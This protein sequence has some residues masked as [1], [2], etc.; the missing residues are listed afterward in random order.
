MVRASLQGMAFIRQSFHLPKDATMQVIYRQLVIKRNDDA[1]IML[2]SA[3]THIRIS[4][5]S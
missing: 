1:A 2:T 3:E 4:E 5:G